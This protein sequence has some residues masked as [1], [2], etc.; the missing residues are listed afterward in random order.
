LIQIEQ[1]HHHHRA[2][3]AHQEE[4]SFHQANQALL[5]IQATQTARAA[6]A[7]QLLPKGRII[8]VELRSGPR[9]YR[10]SEG[11][12]MMT[13]SGTSSCSQL[14]LTGENKELTKWA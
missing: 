10:R 5:E 13:L 2:T 4:P 9:L 12:H 11:L 14:A 7:H 1:G 6:A 8:W 3:E